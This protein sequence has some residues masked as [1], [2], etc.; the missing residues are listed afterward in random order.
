M[1][2]WHLARPIDEPTAS[3]SR[4]RSCGKGVRHGSFVLEDPA[5][6]VN[7]L[8]AQT[9]GMMHL[10]RLGLGVSRSADDGLPEAFVVEP[11]RIHAACV[12]AA[13]LAVG[14]RD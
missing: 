3:A 9:V 14:V 5:F 10:A 11:A 7:C 6:T 2:P 8:Y 12:G 4:S 1:A 13:L